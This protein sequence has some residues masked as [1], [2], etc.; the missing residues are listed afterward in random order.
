MYYKFS[1][2]KAFCIVVYK[3]AESNNQ[4]LL[5]SI[6]NFVLKIKMASASFW[7]KSNPD[8][9]HKKP[10]FFTGWYKTSMTANNYVW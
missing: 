8:F 5:N 6:Y 2:W 1:K 9:I 3:E 4:K 10:E 7:N